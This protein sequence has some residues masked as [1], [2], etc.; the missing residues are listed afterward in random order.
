MTVSKILGLAAVAASIAAT[1]APAMAYQRDH[2]RSVT[3]ATNSYRTYKPATHV[4]VPAKPKIIAV[5]PV[6]T[7]TKV[8]V[9]TREV[10][11]HRGWKRGKRWNRWFNR[12]H[13]HH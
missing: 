3:T 12:H 10:N 4:V 1:S 8:V 7:I 2:S 11:D 9:V 13:F 5:A 6:R